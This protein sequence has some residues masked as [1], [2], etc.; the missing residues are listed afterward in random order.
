MCDSCGYLFSTS[1]RCA[2][3]L[4]VW[5]WFWCMYVIIIIKSDLFIITEY[6]YNKTDS[7]ILKMDF[8]SNCFSSVVKW[9][10]NFKLESFDPWNRDITKSFARLAFRGPLTCK[11]FFNLSFKDKLWHDHHLKYLLCAKIKLN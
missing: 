11:I 10:L 5:F 6:W 7:T 3:V 8:K 1:Q 4:Q 9:S 2:K